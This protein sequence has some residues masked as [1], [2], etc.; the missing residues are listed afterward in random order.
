MN[1]L[2]RLPQTRFR[3]QGG[4]TLLE[5]LLAFVVF[6]L[7]FTLVM[8]IMTGSIRNTVR[9]REY[10]E[11][12]L[13]AQ[14]VMDQLGLDIPLEA[15]TTESGQSGDYEWEVFIGSYEDPVGDTLS[16]QLGE[17]TGI[18]LLQVD[19]VVSWGEPPREKSNDFSTVRAMLANRAL[20][21]R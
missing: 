12:A 18:E 9:A 15:G 14:S 8:E 10:T 11:V 21:G 1:H 7:S 6:A 3:G 4:F 20:S 19:L 13:I 2:H 17:L 5:V 16:V